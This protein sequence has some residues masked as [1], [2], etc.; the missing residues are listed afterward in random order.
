MLTYKTFPFPDRRIRML[1]STILA[2]LLAACTTIPSSGPTGAQLVA[3][4]EDPAASLPIALVE[5]R[6][7]A[8]LP[9]A[10]RP[11]PLLANPLALPGPTERVGHGDVLDIAVY[12]T[13]ISLFGRSS[14]LLSSGSAARESL[15]S[16]GRVER[17]PPF[18]VSDEGTINFPYVGEVPVAG[19]S[20]SEIEE[21]LRRGLRGKSQNPQ[22]LVSIAQAITNSVIVGGDVRQPGRVVLTTNR[23]TLSDVVAL[24]GGNAG[25][26]KDILV[27]VQRGGSSSEIRLAD[28]LAEPEQDIRVLPADRI[29]LVRAPQSF[30]VLGAAGRSDQIVFP[31]PA[32][33]LAEAVALS[34][35][36]NPNA[37]D[38]RAIFVFRTV[39][40]SDGKEVPTVFHLNM[41][42][43]SS[44]I[45]AQR[46]AM[47]DKD[48][49]YVGNAEANQPTKLVQIVSQL[50]FPLVTLGQVVNQ[51]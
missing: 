48:V 46:F 21:L 28:I 29:Q 18:R 40:G 26:V 5:V 14:G 10:A 20:T 51:N 41:M 3:Q 42:Q 44:Y 8:D 23:E 32:F 4:V 50:F 9:V 49:L 7:I 38:P 17:L 22:V 13:G 47:R 15:G 30:S 6:S 36:S 19:R 2:A 11:A 33:S 1:A 34:G 37:G 24:A 39:K 12:E 27:R 45:L 43:A 31:A 35:G 16:D 25:E